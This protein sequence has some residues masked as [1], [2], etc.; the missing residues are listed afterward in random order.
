MTHK[1]F[2]AAG[3]SSLLLIFLVLFL[4][5]FGVLS[6]VS[7]RADRRLTGRALAASEEY[8]AA[9]AYTDD[10]LSTVD[11]LLAESRASLAEERAAG[12]LSKEAASDR[13]EALL[14]VALD[15]LEGV[16]LDGDRVELT[17]A[18]GETREIRTV[19]EV[20]PPEEPGR[21]RVLS[22][23]LCSIGGEDLEDEG[24]NVWPGS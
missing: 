16:R 20:L 23:R 1:R 3:A 6:L 9:D 8:Y 19:L 2:G 22:R 12:R 17:A 18:A 24:L 10:L 21:Y 5:A 13:Y 11:Q 4:T 7:A 14:H 15:G